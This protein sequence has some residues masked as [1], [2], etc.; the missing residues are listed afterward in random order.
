M[1][2]INNAV[3]MQHGYMEKHMKAGHTAR[4]HGYATWTCS[5]DKYMQHRQVHAA[6]CNMGI[7]MQHGHGHVSWIWIYSR[8]MLLT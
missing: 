3:V 2:H 7:Y 4:I 8:N 5:T 1:Q 6:P